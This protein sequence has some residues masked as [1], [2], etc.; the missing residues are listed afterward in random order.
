[1]DP[2]KHAKPKKSKY[3][4]KPLK[5]PG[6]NFKNNFYVGFEWPYVNSNGATHITTMTQDGWSCTCMG[7]THYG[8]CKHITAVHAKMTDEEDDAEFALF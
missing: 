1:M 3:W 2:M 5:L 7:F 8:K 6:L 4:R